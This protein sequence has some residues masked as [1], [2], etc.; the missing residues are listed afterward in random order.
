MQQLYNELPSGLV[1]LDTDGVIEQA[2]RVAVTLLDA[3]LLG[4]LWSDIIARS[5]APKN[6]D[7]HEISLRNGRRI[8]LS[9]SPLNGQAGAA[10][11]INRFNRYAS[12]T[13]TCC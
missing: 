11:I 7:G 13:S 2:N 5:F 8:Q 6:D 9:I 1:V 12:I 10:Y 4:Q 3:P